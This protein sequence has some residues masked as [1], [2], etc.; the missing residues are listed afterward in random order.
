MSFFEEVEGW[1]EGGVYQL[2]D[3]PGFVNNS[4]INIR[5]N[6]DINTKLFKVLKTSWGG[7]CDKIAFMDG[8]GTY[9]AALVSNELKFFK[10]IDTANDSFDMANAPKITGS[11]DALIKDIPV[12]KEN[13]SLPKFGSIPTI[14]LTI[15]NQEEAAAAIEML[16][17]L[18]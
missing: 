8:S 7:R 16:K 14:N 15:R 13:E 11:L 9:N 2:I 17:G 6:E 1:I 3:R 5:I 18:L 4:K 10:M 12:L